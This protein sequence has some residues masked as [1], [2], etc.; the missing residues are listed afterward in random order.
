MDAGII[1]FDTE[2]S[3]WTY[4]ANTSEYYWHRFYSSQP[5]LNFDS[6]EIQTEMLKVVD[7]WLEKGLDGFRVDAI[8]YLFER[9]G[10]ICENLPETHQYIKRLRKHVDDKY[11]DEE[12]ILLAEANMVPDELRQYFGN[13]EDEFQMAGFRMPRRMISFFQLLMMQFTDSK[14]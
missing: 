14:M 2:Y 7:F 6:E 3:N 5:D 13:G 9:E 1:F 8:P 4:D 10:T 11:E 12:K